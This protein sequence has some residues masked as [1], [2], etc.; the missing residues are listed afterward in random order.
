M[1]VNERGPHEGK[2]NFLRVF[3]A[4]VHV[5]V[6]NGYSYLNK[7]DAAIAISLFQRLQKELEDPKISFVSLSPQVDQT[8]YSPLGVEV[9]GEDMSSFLTSQISRPRKAALLASRILRNHSSTDYGRA[10]A[11]ADLIVGCGG[12]YLNEGFGPMTLLHLTQIRAAGRMSKPA[13][14]ANQSIGPFHSKWLM[15][16]AHQQ[17]RDVAVAVIR[18]E[19][20]RPWAHRI[21]LK[22]DRLQIGAD[23]AFAL[24]GTAPEAE[25]AW[26]DGAITNE[27]GPLIVATV[28]HWTF[29]NS[30]DPISHQRRYY[31]AVTA[32]LQ[33]SIDTHDA[34]IVFL[35]QV[36]GP[37]ED[38]DRRAADTV[39]SRLRAASGRVT[40]LREN[41]HPLTL[42]YILSKADLLLGTR[43]HSNIFAL[44][45]GT[46]VVAIAYEHK[47]LGIMESFDL[48]AF[49]TNIT[50]VD[51]GRLTQLV[52]D[53]IS[54][55]N[56][57]SRIIRAQVPAMAESARDGL[58]SALDHTLTQ[59]NV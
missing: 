10:L 46:P 19:R 49:S 20:S 4:L 47:T 25:R 39:A 37:G 16:V 43:M 55:R 11:E 32:A 59:S 26:A 34:R 53:T 21:G 42:R 14:L 48:G 40:V 29:P 18:E 31:D 58:R 45:E 7:G 9:V 3:A 30:V 23:L 44:T 12:G 5:C 38:D 24:E 15:S 35:P 41:L 22:D 50:E 28:R 1:L 57:L 54:R 6:T 36:I 33:S 2:L 8:A 52:N 27:A 17:L 13:L 56:E 51:A